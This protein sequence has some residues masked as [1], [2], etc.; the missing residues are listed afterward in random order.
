MGE[1][2]TRRVKFRDFSDSDEDCQG[3]QVMDDGGN[4]VVRSKKSYWKGL[5]SL[6]MIARMWIQILR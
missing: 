3:D 1:E 4:P 5:S 6:K 2:Y